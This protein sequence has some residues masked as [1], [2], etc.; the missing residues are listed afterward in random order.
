MVTDEADNCSVPV[1]A[2]VSDVSDGNTC[3]EV[4]TQNI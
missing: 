4:I 1:V 3:P 2:F